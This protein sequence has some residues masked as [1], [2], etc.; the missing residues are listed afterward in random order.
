MTAVIAFDVN[1][2]LLDLRVLDQPFE[3][4]LG[5]SNLRQLWFAQMLQL[6]FVGGLTGHYVDFRR[7]QEAALRMVAERVGMVVGSSTISHMVD[8]MNSLPPHSE[9]PTALERLAAT[10]LKVVALVNSLL[11]VGEKQL[12]NAGVR[13]HFDSVI[14]ADAVRHLKPSPEPYQRVA[15]EYGVPIHEV[16]LVAAHSWDI[17]GALAAGCRAAFISRPGM[18]LSPLGEQPDIVATDIAD[19]VDQIIA[20]DLVR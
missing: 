17:S 20:T 11:E 13:G 1:E 8:R 16:R 9:V 7:A 19:A 18:V 12:T 14:S 10:D 2:T 6:S 15:D 5:D 4:L 3:E